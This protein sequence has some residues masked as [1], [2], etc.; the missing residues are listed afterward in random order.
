MQKT[1]YEELE[2]ALLLTTSEFAERY[3]K[4]NEQNDN[5]N[6]SET[7]TIENSVKEK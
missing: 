6:K 7:N 1:A 2:S 5:L 4:K 3:L